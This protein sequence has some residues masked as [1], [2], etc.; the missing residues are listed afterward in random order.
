ML[1]LQ[2]VFMECLKEYGDR[3]TQFQ[4]LTWPLDSHGAI[5]S[6]VTEKEGMEQL[7]VCL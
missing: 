2:Q 6:P 3:Q 1:S 5:F 7:W 4:V